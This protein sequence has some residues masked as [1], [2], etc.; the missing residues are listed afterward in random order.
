MIVSTICYK[1]ALNKVLEILTEE[2]IELVFS[3]LSILNYELDD[4]LSSIVKLPR[5]PEHLKEKYAIFLSNW[6][7]GKEE[8][9]GRDRWD[10]R[11]TAVYIR[12]IRE[13]A[14]YLPIIEIFKLTESISRFVKKTDSDEKEIKRAKTMFNFFSKKIPEASRPGLS[15]LSRFGF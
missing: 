9:G 3:D 8:V 4:S 15:M 6:F 11:G 10:R 7:C 1:N 13:Y 14:Q 12:E 5:C 2:Q